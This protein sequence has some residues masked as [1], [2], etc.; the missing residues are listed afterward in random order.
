MG[1]RTSTV[2]QKNATVIKFVQTLVSIV[3]FM[4]RLGISKFRPFPMYYPMLEIS[5]Y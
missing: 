1:S 2:S 5:K 3:F 4:H